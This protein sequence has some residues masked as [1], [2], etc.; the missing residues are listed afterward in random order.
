MLSRMWS[1]VRLPDGLAVDEGAGDL[2]V[3]VGVVVEHPGR[4]RDRRVQQGVADRLRPGGL[5]EEVAEAGCPERGPRLGRRALLL[6]LRRE[7]AARQPRHEQVRM[8]ADQ[9]L[10]RLAAHRVGD[11][12]AHVAALGDVA[13]V[14][15]ALHQLPP[16]LRD[17]A[18]VTSRARSARPRIR[19]RGPTAAPGRTRPRRVPP[20]A[21]GSVSGPTVSS[22]SMIEPGQPWVMISGSA[23][24]CGDFTWMKWMSSPSISVLNCGKRVQPRLARA[25]V[26]VGRPVPRERLHR[27][28]LHALRAIVDQLLGGPPHGGDAAAQVL[29]GRGPGLQRGTSESPWRRTARSWQTCG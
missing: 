10:G 12:G 19:S 13:G 25:P 1:R 11:G 3:A 4:Q 18:G 17:A 23:S 29:Q 6:G 20:C 8:D 27:R 9:P 7:G 22:N 15:E 16:R 14:A 24:S 5:L 28:Q 26:V 21:V 2:V